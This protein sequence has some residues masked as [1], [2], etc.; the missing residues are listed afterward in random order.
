MT[1]DVLCIYSRD[2]LIESIAD[3]LGPD[4][5][6]HL[7]AVDEIHPAVATWTRGVGRGGKPA[8]L[9]RLA[10]FSRDSDMVF[11]TDDDIGFWPGYLRHYADCVRQLDVA[12]AQPALSLAS[13]HSWRHTLHRPG[14]RARHVNW[15]EQMV[16]SMNR[17]L[18]QA[19]LPFAEK[20][21]RGWGFEMCW[22]PALERLGSRAALIDECP[23]E[24][25][26]RPLFSAYDWQ[27]SMLRGLIYLRRMGTPWRE[28]VVSAHQ[29]AG[30]DDRA[31]VW[32]SDPVSPPAEGFIATLAAAGLEVEVR[33]LVA[34]EP[35]L[36]DPREPT[37]LFHRLAD[38]F[39]AGKGEVGARLAARPGPIGPVAG[40]I[41]AALA[42]ASSLPARWKQ[43][44]SAVLAALSE[45][46]LVRFVLEVYSSSVLV[47]EVATGYGTRQSANKLTAEPET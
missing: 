9:N 19:V 6:L 46:E 41:D 4:S 16:F 24:H 47:P 26:T 3:Q 44:T 35:T 43:E 21:G 40:F 17:P 38:R 15:V 28:M 11:C 32:C 36:G 8:L 33:A 39:G 7:W 29:R 23:A 37:V 2:S 13:Y 25:C 1:I 20:L 30:V 10:S 45:E 27:T 34:H 5:T 31:P 22:L 42:P 12:L 14:L 18:W